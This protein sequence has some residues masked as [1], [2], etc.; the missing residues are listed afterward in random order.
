LYV[1][2]A[3][4]VGRFALALLVGV[5]VT[6]VLAL[7]LPH[8]AFASIGASAFPSMDPGPRPLV[9]GLLIGAG[10]GLV[11]GIVLGLVGRRGA[12]GT[13]GLAVGLAILGLI[14]GALVAIDYSLAVTIALG[15]AVMLALWPA[16]VALDVK[17][18]GIDI[19]ELKNRFYPRLTIET[20]KETI[21]WV[22]KQRPLGPKS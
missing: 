3:T 7:D 18:D 10:V 2:S 19:E 14:I 15:L 11:L 22:Q 21:E 9:V 16:L 12:K 4:I 20:T 8:Q 17:R 5:V 1:P 6:V 13:V